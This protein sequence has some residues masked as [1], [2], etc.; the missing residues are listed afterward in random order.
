MEQRG[1]TKIPSL[2]F[3]GQRVWLNTTNIKLPYSRK[4]KPKRE[5]PFKVLDQ[6]GKYTY[7]IELPKTWKI[8]P[9]FDRW[10]LT[11]YIE[12][13]EYGENFI[14]P[15]P[16]TIDG[17][18]EYEVTQILRHK[19]KDKTR[20]YLVRWKG[21]TPNDDTWE[22]EENLNNSEELLQEYKVRH[23]L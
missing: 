16:D 10:Y 11:P 23:K 4:L 13:P 5:G 3:K 20:R 17:Q 14:P 15:P 19:G 8:H 21:F 12:T 18:Q 1:K 2:L 6:L 7:R 9:V 22:P